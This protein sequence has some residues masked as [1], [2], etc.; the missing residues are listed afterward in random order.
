MSNEAQQL[1][2]QIRSLNVYHVGER[3]APHKPLLVLLALARLKQGESH[4]PFKEVE[5]ALLP[6]LKAYAPP[7]RSRHQPELP[8]WHLQSDGLWKVD[9]ADQLPRQMGGFPRMAALRQ[10]T[11]GF[12]AD[13]ANALLNDKGLADQVVASILEEHFPPS[14]HEDILAAVGLD[15]VDEV[16]GVEDTLDELRRV[17][18]RNP[19]FRENVLRAYEHRCAVTGFRAALAGSYFGCEAA[20]VQW[21]ARGGPDTVANGICLEPT[22]HK[23][24]DAGAWSMT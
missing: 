9:H 16:R 14:M 12:T 3:R 15:A 13:A 21:H 4:M 11:A 17:L 7:V 22:L 18:P 1:L 24:L 19:I 8:Y 2:K 23:L 6:L 5:T 20:H 10:S